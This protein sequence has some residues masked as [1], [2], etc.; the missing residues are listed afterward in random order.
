MPLRRRLCYIIS[1]LDATCRPFS[2]LYEASSSF[3]CN[4]FSNFLILEK[5]N[6]KSQVYAV[7]ITGTV[8]LLAIHIKAL[9]LLAVSCL[10]VN[11]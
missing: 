6:I 3:K 8:M 4:L 11:L 2:Y 7:S 5:A 9:P 1:S 10:A